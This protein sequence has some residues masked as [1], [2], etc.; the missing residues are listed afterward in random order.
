M[1]ELILKPGPVLLWRQWEY[2]EVTEEGDY[3]DSD[4]TTTAHEYLFESVTIDKDVLL[5]DIFWLLDAAPILTAILRRDFSDALLAEAR[6]GASSSWNNAYAPEGIEFLELYQTWHLNTA[7]REYDSVHRLDFH[8]VGYLL[9]EDFDY[10][11]GNIYPAGTRIHW[12]VSTTPLRELLAI[13]IRINPS[14]SICENDLS[15]KKYG[16]E[17]EKIQLMGINLGQVLHG[18]LWELSWHGGPESQSQFVDELNERVED[19]KNHRPGVVSEIDPYGEDGI[20]GQLDEPGFQTFFQRLG[21]HTKKEIVFTLHDLE[22]DE[23]VQAGLRARLSD[24]ITIHPEFANMA[25]RA[26]RTLF[27]EAK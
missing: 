8:G 18:I 2:D 15:A 19:I 9:R 6:K 20:F 13:P 3:V 26:F 22:D 11:N 10:G 27:R 12:S 24:D 25:A 4:V 14:V 5:S 17:L 23:P 1:S 16:H 7:T 21:T